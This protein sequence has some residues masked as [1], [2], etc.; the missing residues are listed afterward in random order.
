MMW[1]W[2]QLEQWLDNPKL[3]AEVGVKEGRCL[4]HLLRAFPGLSMYAVDPWESQAGGAEDYSEWDFDKIY[5]E[6]TSNTQGVRA[7]VIELRKYS[8]EAA[9]CVADASLDFVFI[10]AQH[11]YESVKTDIQAWA[12]KVRPGGLISGHDYDPDPVRNYGVIEAVTEIFD[13]VTTGANF[14]W[15]KRI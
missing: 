15:C 2:H 3:G 9:E 8:T 14:T 7:R 11:D 4:S 13:E 10:D 12:P 6:Y 5:Q 1:R